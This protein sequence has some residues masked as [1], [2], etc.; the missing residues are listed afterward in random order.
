MSE[1]TKE[2][3]KAELAEKKLKVLNELLSCLGPVTKILCE[4][5]RTF[6]GSL[7]ANL[8]DVAQSMIGARCLL[9]AEINLQTKTEAN[10]FE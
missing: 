5:S 3:L 2:T 7:G 8:G 1:Q 4:A 6:P 9:E 10:E